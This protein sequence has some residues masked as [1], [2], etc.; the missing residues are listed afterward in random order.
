MN[1]IDKLKKFTA[2]FSFRT[3]PGDTPEQFVVF[4]HCK[5]KEAKGIADKTAFEAVENHVHFLENLSKEEFQSVDETAKDLAAILHTALK[6]KYPERKFAAYATARL[7][8]DLIL[9][10]HQV[11][12]GEPLYYIPEEFQDSGEKV[13]LVMA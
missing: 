4:S 3:L 2:L 10:F 8:G 5:L 13:F 1:R 6:A 11:W 7:Q 12:E 9:R